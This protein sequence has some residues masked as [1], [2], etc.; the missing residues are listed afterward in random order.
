MS[1]TSPSSNLKHNLQAPLTEIAHCPFLS[2]CRGWR[3]LDGGEFRSRN[4]WALFNI[5]NFRINL[6]WRWFGT[7]LCFP[8]SQNSSSHDCL[9][10]LIVSKCKYNM[11]RDP[12]QE[13]FHFVVSYIRT[14]PQ[15]RLSIALYWAI[16]DWEAEWHSRPRP[17]V[18]VVKGAIRKSHFEEE[19]WRSEIRGVKCCIEGS[20]W[21]SR[22]SSSR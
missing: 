3:W 11:Q 4:F 8:L 20:M 14:F 2:P 12:L 18:S 10:L 21:A 17:A 7:R 19:D 13:V 6:F 16:W 1:N 5:S 15:L 22:R 9:N